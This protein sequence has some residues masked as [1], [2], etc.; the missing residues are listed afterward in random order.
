[1]QGVCYLQDKSFYRA[2]ALPKW[3][4]ALRGYLTTAATI[5]MLLTGFHYLREVRRYVVE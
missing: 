3:Y 2:G 1:M 5:S 4:M